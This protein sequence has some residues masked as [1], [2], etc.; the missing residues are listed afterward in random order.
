M[1]R[2]TQTPDAEAEDILDHASD[3]RLFLAAAHHPEAPD[4]TW[5][6]VLIELADV[7]IE[8]F[9]A[10]VGAFS[11]DLLI[12]VAYDPTDRARVFAR[13]PVA[14]YARQ[15]LIK[16]LNKRSNRFHVV[17]LQLGA[18]TAEK[19]LDPA[20]LATDLEALFVPEDTVVMAVVDDG[21]AIA[22]DLLRK[23]PEQSRVEHATVFEAQPV[24]GGHCSVGRAF[25]R[26]EIDEVLARST[27]NDVLDEDVFY[28]QTTVVDWAARTVS[29]VARQASHGTLVAGVAAGHPMRAGCRNRPVICAALPARLVEDTTGVDSLP[30]LY[31]AFHILLKQAR[32]FRLPNGQCAPVI[33]NFSFGNS[34]GP[35]DGTGLF[36]A[37]FEHYFGP[38]GALAPDQQKAWLT[39]PAGNINLARLHAVARGR[40]ATTLSLS[41]Q[42]DDRTPS[43]VQMWMPTDDTESRP[44]L[45]GVQVTAPTGQSGAITSKPGQSMSLVDDQGAEIARLACQYEA[46]ATQRALV[47]LSVSPT[48]HLAGRAPLAPAG[49]WTI[50][51]SSSDMIPDEEV[52][53]WIRRDETL[54]GTRSGGR[55][56]WFSNSDYERFDPFGRPLAVDPPGTD[57]PIR[58]SGSLS[59]FAC[60]ASPL[61]V[62]AFSEREARVSGYS[63]AG[64]LTPRVPGSAPARS[65]P[66]LAALG[67]DSYLMRG[68][69]GAGSRS[70]S[71]ARMSGTS[72]AAPR[73][74]RYAADMIGEWE[75]G[76]ADW[77][78]WAVKRAPFYLEGGDDPPRSGAG[79][80]RID[81]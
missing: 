57:C 78:R 20:A 13:Q 47:T 76:A 4:E 67:D 51:I 30:T 74:A 53:V 50:K 43:M 27:F 77:S 68:V 65:G 7:S 49:N 56:A 64:P 10:A 44:G 26:A 41:V 46:G 14:I 32:R 18:I 72:V 5:W 81:V 69:R 35:H 23:G 29:P 12:P 59:G 34:G 71:S 75:A 16:A 1:N 39:L 58:R 66:D 3:F 17:A 33:F 8:T 48:A 28:Q 15:P 45:V 63:A 24:A 19:Y 42:P 2:W 6:S 61:V 9:E 25:G 36:S 79:G 11:A 22:H 40:R 70:G 55:Q 21:I 80:V 38:E 60:G 73:V 52:H 31:L 37:L 54:P 62:A